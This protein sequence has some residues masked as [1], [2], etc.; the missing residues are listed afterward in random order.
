MVI[1]DVKR[2]E[3][4]ILHDVDQLPA[5]PL[6][7]P[8]TLNKSKST[9]QG[10]DQ[11]LQLNGLSERSQTMT[12]DAPMTPQLPKQ[13]GQIANSASNF[14]NIKSNLKTKK[15]QQLS[16]SGKQKEDLPLSP[17]L[18]PLMPQDENHESDA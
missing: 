14:S 17:N 1:R 2:K 9:S 10:K 8:M 13:S 12:L 4:G 15:Q 16:P 6:L 11:R 3:V 7:S 18:Q 5:S